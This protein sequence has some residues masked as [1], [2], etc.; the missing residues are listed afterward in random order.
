MIEKSA[1]YRIS[2][3][4]RLRTKRPASGPARSVAI[5]PR[6]ELAALLA[7]LARDLEN[8]GHVATLVGF[9]KGKRPGKTGNLA[10]LYRETDA[11]LWL[12]YQGTHEVLEWF[13]RKDALALALGGETVLC[14]APDLRAARR[15]NSKIG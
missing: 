15:G 4:I 2:P 13:V 10:K 7:G 11:D 6:P 14:L 1:G 3:P 9:S 8:D 5:E 12:I